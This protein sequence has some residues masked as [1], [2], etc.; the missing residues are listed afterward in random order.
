MDAKN[1]ALII[2]Q[3]NAG[4]S[5]LAVGHGYLKVEGLCCKSLRRLVAVVG[6]LV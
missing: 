6:L 1:C 3:G 2:N 4:G 5:S